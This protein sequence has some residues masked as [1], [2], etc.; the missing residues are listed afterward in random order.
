M[1]AAKSIRTVGRGAR[2]RSWEPLIFRLPPRGTLRP[3]LLATRSSR[4]S[5]STA[6]RRAALAGGGKRREQRQLA[7]HH[8]YGVQEREPVRVLVGPQRR[9]VHQPAHGEVR[10]QQAPELLPH[11]LGGLAAQHHPRAP[12]VRLQLG[13]RALDLPPLVVQR[14]QLRRGS[15]DRVEQGGDQPGERL[16]PPPPPPPRDLPPPPHP[17][18]PR[19]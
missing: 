19:P 5:A 4:I 3:R 7:P 12:R 10:Q 14:G 18:P 11:Q 15:G 16:R 6:S 9:L 17:P 2:G 8:P 13:E 1:A